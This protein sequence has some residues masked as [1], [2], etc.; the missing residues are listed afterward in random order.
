MTELQVPFK[1]NPEL[2]Q[3]VEILADKEKERINQ[4]LIVPGHALLT[5]ETCVGENLRYYMDERRWHLQPFQSGEVP[6]YVDHIRAGLTALIENQNALLIFSGGRTRPGNSKWSEASSYLNIAR[7]LPEWDDE[8]ERRIGTEDFARDS[9][10]NVFFSE[11]QF[12]LRIGHFPNMTTVFGWA[13]KSPRFDLHRA[14]LGIPIEEFK[15]IGVNNPSDIEGAQ[16]GESKAFQQFQSDP[17]G[18]SDELMRKKHQ[19]DPHHD[20]NPYLRLLSDFPFKTNRENL[21]RLLEEG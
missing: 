21:R 5:D 4:L 1:W 18:I 16:K 19:R 10:S 9:V 8:L 14:T 2:R 6:F 3:P 17:F 7:S 13:F 20:S 12:D 15:Y 11:F